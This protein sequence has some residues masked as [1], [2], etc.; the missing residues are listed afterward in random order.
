MDMLLKRKR[1]TN[2]CL[3]NVVCVLFCARACFSNTTVED[4][5]KKT[6]SLTTEI[7]SNLYIKII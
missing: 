4:T 5:G 6:N 3:E 1:K 2:L 7:V